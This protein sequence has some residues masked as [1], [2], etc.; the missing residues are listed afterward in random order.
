MNEWI[1]LQ[2]V[3]LYFNTLNILLK[4]ISCTHIHQNQNLTHREGLTVYNE[5]TVN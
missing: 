4:T 2:F 1:F 5:L 3:W